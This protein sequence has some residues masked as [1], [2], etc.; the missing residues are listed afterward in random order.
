MSKWLQMERKEI[1]YSASDVNK[2]PLDRE[3]NYPL[4]VAA[5]ATDMLMVTDGRHSEYH[6]QRRMSARKSDDGGITRFYMATS[7]C[8]MIVKNGSPLCQTVHGAGVTKDG[9]V[10]FTDRGPHMLRTLSQEGLLVQVRRYQKMAP[11]L[12]LLFPSPHPCA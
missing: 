5:V 2:M 4:A 8:V 6:Q 7:E 9:H 12:L 1:K 3:I 10:I 11:T